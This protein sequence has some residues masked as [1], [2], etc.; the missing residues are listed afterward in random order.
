M[1]LQQV[2]IDIV[3]EEKKVQIPNG[4]SLEQQFINKY[5]SQFIK[6]DIFNCKKCGNKGFIAVLNENNQVIF[7]TC[8]CFNSRRNRQRL[9]EMGLLEFIDRK[10]SSESDDIQE[11]WLQLTKEITK[12]Y[13]KDFTRGKKN[14]LFIG[15][16]IGSGKTSRCAFALAKMMKAKPELTVE[17]FNWDTSYKDLAFS[18]DKEALV[19]N[20]KNADILYID[21]F[22][23]IRNANELSQMERELAKMIIDFRYINKKITLISS[24]LFLI[25]I[26][27]IDE[28]IGSRIYEMT[29]SGNYMISIN[30]QEG[31]NLRLRK[32]NRI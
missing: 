17:Y 15:G 7:K 9:K 26:E 19:Y 29:N 11:K 27:Q 16:N 3:P 5:N 14:W 1:N 22:M 2:N 18:K 12:N 30:R 8:T 32:E 13:V 10:Y 28:A 20:L 31:R 23:R 25:E 4:Y 6:D 21:D 24:E